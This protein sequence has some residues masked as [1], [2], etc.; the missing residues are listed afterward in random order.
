MFRQP[1]KSGRLW[2]IL[3]WPSSTQWTIHTPCGNWFHSTI[4][5]ASPTWLSWHR[6]A[7]AC[8]L[9]LAQRKLRLCLANHR[10]G[11]F[12]NLACDWLSIVWAYSEQEIENGPWCC[13][14]RQQMWNGDSV[15]STWSVLRKRTDWILPPRT[16][17][18]RSSLRVQNK[19]SKEF[20]LGIVKKWAVKKRV[21]FQQENKWFQVV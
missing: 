12:S 1:Q 5:T 14:C 10:A 21:P 15:L 18:W 19:A 7:W 13:Q 9:S 20:L 3:W 6:Y 8:F 11:Y 16:C 4:V 2:S 17:S